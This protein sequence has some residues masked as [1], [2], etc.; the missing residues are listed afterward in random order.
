MLVQRDW[1]T[2][3]SFVS[4][5]MGLRIEQMRKNK[6]AEIHMYIGFSCPYLHIGDTKI[7]LWKPLITDI[8][9]ETDNI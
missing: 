6:G 3:K 4:I 9:K 2:G 8:I 1:S 5:W 7:G